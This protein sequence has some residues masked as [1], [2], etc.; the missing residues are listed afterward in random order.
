ME[1]LLWALRI[2]NLQVYLF[3]RTMP[4]LEKNHIIPSLQFFPQDIGKYREQKKR[5]DLH[6]GSM[7]HFCHVQHEKDVFNYQGTEIHVLLIDEVTT[8]TEFIYDYLRGRVRCTL[9]VPEYWRHKVPGIYC[10]GNPGNIGHV[11]CK[12]RFIDPKPP[13][14]VWKTAKRDGGMNRQYIPSKLQDNPTLLINDPTYIDRV[15][16]LPEPYRTAYLEGDWDIFLG[17]MFNFDYCVHSV[18]PGRPS[19]QW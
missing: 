6:N 4:E 5:W 17:Q 1:G 11:F 16:A 14:E 9:P 15:D 2:P 3:R 10:S 18:H 13:M 8:F 7:L 19:K 12:Q